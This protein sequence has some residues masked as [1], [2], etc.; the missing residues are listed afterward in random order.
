MDE[1][2]FKEGDRVQ[3]LGIHDNS[4]VYQQC[5]QAAGLVPLKVYEVIYVATHSLVI[6]TE[7]GGSGVLHHRR[8]FQKIEPEKEGEVYV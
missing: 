4:A 7:P 3:F 2:K 8:Y 6:V 1:S 5:T